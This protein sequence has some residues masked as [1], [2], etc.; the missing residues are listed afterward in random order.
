VGIRVG[1]R[2][3]GG[4]KRKRG[5][6]S[7]QLAV[8]ALYLLRQQKR[9]RRLRLLLAV[10]KEMK[11]HDL[12]ERK[13][14]NICSARQGAA[15]NKR[16]ERWGVLAR[17][18]AKK[19]KGSTKKVQGRGNRLRLGN[20]AANNQKLWRVRGGSAGK[21]VQKSKEKSSREGNVGPTQT[22]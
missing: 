12:E 9:G 5:W 1:V 7:E 21:G 22:M 14:R 2:E 3:R 15:R 16:R 10:P 18:D 6:A 19:K 17:S 11:Q 20:N 13:M 4:R 8:M